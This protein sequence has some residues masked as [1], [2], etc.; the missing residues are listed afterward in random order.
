MGQMSK[1]ELQEIIIEAI[2]AAHAAAP[3]PQPHVCAFQDGELQTLKDLC[4]SFK[5]VKESAIKALAASFVLG[6][7]S[8]VY[9]WIKKAP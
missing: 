8:A 9:Y 4:E 7:G 6:I 1:E 3:P 5:W 2:K